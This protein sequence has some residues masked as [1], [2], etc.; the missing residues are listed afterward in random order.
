MAA[1]TINFAGFVYDDAGDAVS[2]ATV[3]IY[4]KNSTST[5]RESSSITTNSSGYWSY[6]HATPGEFDVEVV[7][8]A[9]KRRFKFDDKI[10]IAEVDAE[11]ISIRGNEGAIAALFMYADEGDDV[12]DQWRVDVGTDGVLAFGND[13]ASQ[14]SFVDHLTITPNSTVANS[15][16]AFKGGVTIAGDLT[17][18]GDDITMATNT[19][20]AILV[21]D[22]TNYNPVVPTGVIDLANDGAFTVDNTFIS[23]QTEITSGLAAADELLY[24]DGG[25]VKK[26]GLDNLVE[27]GPAL[28]TED[29]IANGDYILFLDGG[30]SG[31]MNKE[32]VHDLA[33]LFAGSGLTA[34]NSVIAVDTLNQ[35]TSG[36][37]AIATTVTITDNESTDEDNA[38]IFTSGGDVDGGNIGLESDGTLTYNPSTGKITATGFLGAIDGILGANSAAA[39]TGTTGV[40][41]TSIDITGSAGIILENDETITN[42]TNGTVAFSG[43]I[44][45]PNAGNIG[46]ASDLDAIAIASNGVVNFTQAP[47]VASAAVLT[48]GVE[49]IWVPAAAMTPRDNAGCAALTTVAAGTNG[50]PDFH[51]LDFDNSSDEHAQF[52]IAMPK[53]WDGGNVYYYVYWIGL[54]ATTGVTW[55]LEVLSLNDN[56]EFNQAYVNPILVDDDSQGDVTELL[57]SAKSAAIACSGADNDLLCFQ[58]YRDVSAGNDDMAGDARLW[59]LLLEYTTN[60]ATDA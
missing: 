30:A 6:A 1:P 14:G 12:S 38:I 5:A 50:R 42:S 59:G 47:T 2:G 57:V 11:K 19:S 21:A 16:V 7:S 4:D 51:V 40:F 58:V 27:L 18:T 25:T 46:S 39:V 24:S 20:T 55:G 33:T 10:H 37:A 32:A 60:A 26:I 52:T 54:A 53:S 36:T 34:T 43:G 48:A 29:A 22:G 9:S 3:H 35:D 8:G 15:T 23:S 41:T 28:S 31:N 45:I 13:A 56:E 49:N 17:V 44:A